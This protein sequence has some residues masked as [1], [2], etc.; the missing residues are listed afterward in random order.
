M[1]G[2][3]HAIEVFQRNQYDMLTALACDHRRFVIPAYIIHRLL[4]AS[5][6]LTESQDVH[7]ELQGTLSDP[8]KK[9]G[10]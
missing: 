6:R 5:S 4:Q 1:Q 3:L 2:L 8:G 7:Q 10:V 9:I